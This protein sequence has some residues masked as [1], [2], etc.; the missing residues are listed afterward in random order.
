MAGGASP[1]PVFPRNFPAISLL[2]QFEASCAG[3]L[4]PGW[5]LIIRG[6]SNSKDD[7][8][9]INFLSETGDIAFH[10]KPCFSNTTLVCNSFQANRWGHEEVS[11]VFPLELKEPFEIEVFSDH[12]CFHVYVHENK[13]LEYEHRQKPLSA[14]TKVQVLNDTRFSSVELSKKSLYLG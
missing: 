7:E 3:G 8:F 10:F 5:S 4:V 1:W 12:E 9:E 2:L 13:I 11:D 6:H 14:I